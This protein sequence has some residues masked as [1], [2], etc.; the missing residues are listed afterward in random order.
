MATH[1][2]KCAGRSRPCLKQQ[3]ATI[4]VIRC[5]L[6]PLPGMPPPHH[7]AWFPCFP[8]HLCRWDQAEADPSGFFRFM[9]LLINFRRA[10]PA[11][12]RTAYVTDRDIQWH[13]EVGAGEQGAVG[14]R[15]GDRSE[16][17]DRA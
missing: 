12:Q 17:G 7:N 10:T 11:L 8:L 14:C 2:G 5:H 9:R 15:S 4:Q 6:H 3:H 1:E 16:Q 13:G